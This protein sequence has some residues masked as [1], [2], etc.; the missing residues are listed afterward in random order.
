M[1]DATQ[2]PARIVAL[3]SYGLFFLALANGITAV[4][5]LVLAY[6]KRGDTRGTVWES[7][8]SNMIL[9]FWVSVASIVLLLVVAMFGI[10]DLLSGF[11]TTPKE[12]YFVLPAMFLIGTVWLVWYLYRT[13]RGFIR[14]LD[15]K[16][17]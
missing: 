13:V 4:I 1:T 6:I 10:A 7:H 2:T 11:D 14:A 5:G 8:F 15:G 16:A 12:F 9:V 17:Y 3:I